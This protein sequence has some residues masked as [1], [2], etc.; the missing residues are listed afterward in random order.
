M[1]K[2][3]FNYILKNF[4]KYF[5]LVVLVIYGFG[6]ILNLF[7]E[8]E[9]FKKIN[10]SIFLPFVLTIIYVPSTILN[11]LPFIIFVSSMLY[12]IKMRN[13]KD[14]LTLKVYGFSSLKIFFIFAIT[15]FILGWIVLIIANPLTSSMT[16]FY[17]KTK[18]EYARDIDHL[19]TFNKNGLWIKESLKDGERIVTAIKP[20]KNSLLDV[21]IFQFDKNFLLKKKILSKS[22]DIKNFNWT[23]TDVTI[24][25]ER[26]SLY[27][28]KNFE[29]YQ[30]T[31]IYNYDK[32]INLF[33]NSDT[34]SFINLVFNYDGLLEKGYNNE[35]LNQSLHSMLVFPF[36]LSLMTGIASILTMHAIKKSE[37]FRF[38]IV[39]LITCVLV[40]YLKDLSL[41]LGKTGRIPIIL[42]IWTPII[43][44]S[45][46]TFAGILQI[47]E[48]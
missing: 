27:E 19:I 39:G 25:E 29:N 4:F 20:E 28:K 21:T 18:S 37:N 38:I 43:T 10:V 34:L 31:S 22:A 40:Y 26:N 11:L 47:N 16:Q 44:L 45:L 13:N 7:E 17:E 46:F 32:I 30:I 9:F 35:F 14:F 6:I 24:F 23:L 5:F 36:F 42:S 41:A 33:N 15:A 8:I 1:S 3:I 2:I 48:K 12:M